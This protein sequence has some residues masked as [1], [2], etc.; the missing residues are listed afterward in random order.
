[1]KIKIGTYVRIKKTRPFAIY[2]VVGIRSYKVKDSENINMLLI[3]G[4][5]NEETGT[6]RVEDVEL[7]VPYWKPSDDIG[8]TTLKECEPKEEENLE[9]II[10]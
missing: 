8:Y 4:V 6:A 7:A 1:M 10:Q 5:N 9:E 2:E 3:W